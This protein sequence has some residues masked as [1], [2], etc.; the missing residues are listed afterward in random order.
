MAV[1]YFSSNKVLDRLFVTT[2]FTP[3]TTYYFGLSTTTLNIDG[4]GATK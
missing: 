2:A 4:T 3:A 1:T